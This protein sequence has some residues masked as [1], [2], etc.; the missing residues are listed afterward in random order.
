MVDSNL[1]LELFDI[2]YYLN[3]KF[4]MDF[5]LNGRIYENFESGEDCVNYMVEEGFLTK[6]GGGLTAEEISKK[7]KVSELKDL[8]RQHGLKVSG[9][10]QELVE[11]LMPVLSSDDGDAQ[12]ALTEKAYDFL[13]S[14]GWI[15]LY[16]FALVAFDFEDFE[17]Y[18]QKSGLDIMQAAL[19]FSDECIKSAF[20]SQ[21]ILVLL[22]SL[23]AKAHVYAFFQ[24]YESFVDLDL[25]RY[26]FGLNPP[27]M[28]PEVYKRYVAIIPANI[29]N[30]RNVLEKFDFGSLKKKYDKIW[31]VLDIKNITV[32]KKTSFKILERALAGADID[33][34]NYELKVK[35]L[36][37]KY[38]LDDNEE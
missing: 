14:Y 31:K 19:N 7:Y 2:I 21:N 15:N 5:I 34:L 26:I 16:N 8:L 20:E 27:F 25:Q 28:D 18:Y 38:L 13:K 17:K 29:I 12:Y 10:K 33:A 24:D 35:Y 30:L 11:R 4:D 23:S 6:S 9:K 22:D 3:K 32:S 37:K 36:D 1:K